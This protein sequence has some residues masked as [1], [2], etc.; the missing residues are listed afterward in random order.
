MTTPQKKYSRSIF[1]YELENIAAQHQWH[2]R[3]FGKTPLAFEHR[4]VESLAESLYSVK[5]LPALSHGEIMSVVYG[6]KL[7]KEERTR[8]YASLIALGVQRLMLSYLTDGLNSK[9]EDVTEQDCERA[10]KIAEEVRDFALDWL[11]QRREDGDDVFRGTV[12][13]DRQLAPALDAYDEGVALASFGQ[14]KDGGGEG[15]EFLE[16]AQVQL[17]RALKTLEQLSPRLQTT[18][19][20]VYWHREVRKALASVQNVLD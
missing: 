17:A 11:D 20:W 13:V 1:A 2:I 3:D 14:M 12:G 19:D 9:R 16:Q 15:R 4:K 6:L 8:I 18:E 10:W 7:T 5:R